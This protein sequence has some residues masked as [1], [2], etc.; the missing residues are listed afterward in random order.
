[1]QLTLIHLR[2]PDISQNL[3][4]SVDLDLHASCVFHAA[5]IK[6]STFPTHEAQ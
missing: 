2:G 6:Q 3:S 1:M 4:L 5:V